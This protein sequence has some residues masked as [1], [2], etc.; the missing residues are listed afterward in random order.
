MNPPPPPPSKLAE[1]MQMMVENQR[2]LTETIN[3][4]ANQAGRNAQHGL[5]PNQYS[6]FKGFHGYQAPSFREAEE[7]LQAQEW[8]N[9][10][11]QKFRLLQLTD[12]LRA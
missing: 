5:E 12:S 8:L 11:E 2:L 1:L 9:T 3:Q 4:M 10:V 6:S 7:H